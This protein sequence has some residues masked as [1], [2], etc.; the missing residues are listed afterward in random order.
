MCLPDNTVPGI[1]DTRCP[2][3]AHQ[4]DLQP[5]LQF[6]QKHT[7][8]FVLIMFVIARRRLVDVVVSQE[9]RGVPGILTRDQV[10]LAQHP[11]CPQRDVFQVSDWGGDHIKGSGHVEAY[12]PQSRK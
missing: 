7:S 8:L 3:I 9:P 11:Q 1:R 2:G 4:R 6:L 10:H 5:A 12:S